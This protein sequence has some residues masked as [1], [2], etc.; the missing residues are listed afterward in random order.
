MNS[1]STLDAQPAAADLQR[2]RQPG[3]C[4]AGPADLD[5]SGDAASTVTSPGGER[6]W[7]T[8]P[9]RP[10]ARIHARCIPGAGCAGL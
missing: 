8:E 1:Q 3:E 9:H 7:E 2:D 5:C 10:M 6:R 4:D